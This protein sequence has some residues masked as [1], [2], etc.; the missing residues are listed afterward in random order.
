MRLES[1]TIR[2]VRNLTDIQI[3]PGA[4]VNIIYG[5][6]AAGKTALLESIYLL[7]KARS[8]R[9][10]HI[11]EVIQH[12]QNELMVSA[13]IVDRGSNKKTVS[14][15]IRKSSK[16]TEIRHNGERVKA[17][18]EQAKN[19]V[20]QT[21]IPDN[22]KVLTGSPKDRRKWIDWALFHVEQDYLQVWHS[23]HHA[24]RNRNALLRKQGKDDEFFVWEDMMSTTAKKLGNMWRNYLVR[25]QQYYQEIAG[26]HPCG[27]VVF[28]VKNEKTKT[29][30]FL[31]YLQSTRQSDIKAGYTQHGPHKADFEFKVYNKHANTVFSR[32][33]I[34]LFV[35][36]LSIA[37]A[38][39][40]K[41]EKGVSPI[42]LADDLAAE[43]DKKTVTMVLR[44]L[45]DEKMQLF[46]T[47]TEPDSIWNDHKE[48]SLF[49]V[50]HGEVK[51]C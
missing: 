37:Q 22:T 18:S 11:K 35:T 25:L 27:S 7:S 12:N 24:L 47:T 5:E 28:D 14:T 43:L 29:D 23:Y 8:F 17:V 10:A 40:L 48:T 20:V 51:R 30:S 2:K 45:Y 36:M 21:A 3:T 34:K 44:L 49:H 16:E 33:Q 6:N 9:T 31:K 39:L 42:I 15:G 46:I 1:L 13:T 41:K 4:E 19:V 26:E 38:N 50:K 32:G